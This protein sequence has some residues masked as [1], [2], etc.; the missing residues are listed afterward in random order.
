M[1]PFS[2]IAAA[3][4]SHVLPFCLDSCSQC[5]LCSPSLSVASQASRATILHPG[6][7]S[8]SPPAGPP[9]F[10]TAG[11]SRSPG[12]LLLLFA[13]KQCVGRASKC[14]P[15][16]RPS[17]LEN[18]THTLSNSALA[19][20]SHDHVISFCSVPPNPPRLHMQACFLQA[21]PIGLR[22]AKGVMRLNPP[23]STLVQ[24]GG[25]LLPCPHCSGST[26]LCCASHVLC[27]R[28]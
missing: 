16:P 26:A 9:I 8:H 3:C 15:L 28:A 21:V 1:Q 23:G 12:L 6:Q 7:R 22:S 19:C 20:S 13:S 25:W 18:A 27:T 5:S 4:R 10:R 17:S 24:E 14:G 11:I 2:H